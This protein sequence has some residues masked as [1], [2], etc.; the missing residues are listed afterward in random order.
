MRD[1]LFKTFFDSAP[2]AVIIADD[3]GKIIVSNHQATKLFGYTDQEFLH[4]QVENLMPEGFRGRHAIHRDSYAANPKFRKMG[5]GLELV[6]QRKDGT[7]FFAEIS[8]SPVRIENSLYVSAAIRDVTE[9]KELLTQMKNQQ[10][11]LSSHNSR[12]LDFAHIVSHNL[13]SH[14]SNLGMMLDFHQKSESEEEKKEIFKHLQAISKSLSDTVLHLKEII[15]LDDN[16]SQKVKIL[17]LRD[18]VERTHHILSADLQTTGGQLINNISEEIKIPYNPAYMESILLNLISNSIK[19]RHPERKPIITV[20]AVWNEK[21]TVLK[22]SDNGLGID[23]KRHGK[24]IFELY[25]VFHANKD[26]HGVGLFITR[27]QIESLGGSIHVQS[28]VGKGTTFEIFLKNA[29]VVVPS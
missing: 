26:A 22:I 24:E 10:I 20:N 7:E 12:L 29:H 17:N 1:T 16:A 8:L 4:I 25:K 15:T 19:Y 11:L 18:Y 13:R 3:Q 9:K 28:D 5:D 21:H 23:L 27:N 6:A 14:A 2:D